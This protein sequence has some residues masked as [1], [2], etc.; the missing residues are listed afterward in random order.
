M[1]L[2]VVVFVVLLFIMCCYFAVVSVFVS[3]C[4]FIVFSLFVCDIVVFVV[5]FSLSQELFRWMCFV[6][7]LKNSVCPLPM[8][9]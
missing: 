8:R 3:V 1:C 4:F 9:Y 2:C 7:F 6:T 5:L